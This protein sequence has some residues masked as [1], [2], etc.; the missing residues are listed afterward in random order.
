M[1][2]EERAGDGQAQVALALRHESDGRHEMA[3]GWFARAAQTGQP[4]ALRLLAENLMVHPP[5]RP[6]ESAE[7]MRT[8]AT[9]IRTAISTFPIWAGASRAGGATPSSSGM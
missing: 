4:D 6:R 2:I 5:I 8:A 3:R 1:E 7:M 9:I